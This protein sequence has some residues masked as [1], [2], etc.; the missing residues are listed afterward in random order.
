[1]PGTPGVGIQRPKTEEEKISD[2]EHSDYQMGVG[3]I[4]YLVKHSRPDIVKGVREISQS[5]DGAT[6]A[7]LKAMTRIIK[8]VIDT[9]GWGLKIEPKLEG[10]EL[11]I[12]IIYCD[13]DYAGVKET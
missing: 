10:Q 11:Y 13:S 3:M 6:Y 2:K 9:K 1:M 12:I 5:V 7:S 4:L 8:F